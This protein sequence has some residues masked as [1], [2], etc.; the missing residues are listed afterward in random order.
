[1]LEPAKMDRVGV[2]GLVEHLSRCVSDAL[3]FECI[4]L[5]DCSS[6]L[7]GRLL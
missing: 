7:E 1:M 2:M 3:A 4:N 6:S 5:P